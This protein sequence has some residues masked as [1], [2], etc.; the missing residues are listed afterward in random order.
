[1]ELDSKMAALWAGMETISSI[2]LK[3][4]KPE[5]VIALSKVAG[6][7]SVGVAAASAV[8]SEFPSPSLSFSS[9]VNDKIVKFLRTQ[10]HISVFMETIL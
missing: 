2:R 9:P 4:P 7:S 6:P 3:I 10:V 1:M 5:L 8:L